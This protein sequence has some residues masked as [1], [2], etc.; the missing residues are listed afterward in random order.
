MGFNPNHTERISVEAAWQ[1][2][3]P[4]ATSGGNRMS[5]RNRCYPDFSLEIT[6]GADPIQTAPQ[7][8]LGRQRSLDRFL[9]FR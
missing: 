1:R 2:A 3:Q 6:P 8:S 9:Y 7:Q 5:R 4:A